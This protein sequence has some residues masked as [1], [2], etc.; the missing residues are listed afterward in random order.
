MRC[1]VVYGR[2]SL[3][4]YSV[5]Q[6]HGSLWLRQGSVARCKG[7]SC[8]R[9]LPSGGTQWLKEIPSMRTRSWTK[10]DCFGS[11]AKGAEGEFVVK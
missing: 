1:V 9:V 7:V 4:R 3:D 8:I 6:L 2:H 11:V 5:L 10:T